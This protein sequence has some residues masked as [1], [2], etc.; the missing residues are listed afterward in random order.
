MA[1]FHF[2]IYC[3]AP[4]RVIGYEQERIW[5]AIDAI[6][7]ARDNDDVSFHGSICFSNM[8][9]SH[10]LFGM[11]RY[12]L[13][14]CA[15]YF[16]PARN[17][18]WSASCVKYWAELLA[19]RSGLAGL[20]NHSRKFGGSVR[21]MVSAFLVTLDAPYRQYHTPTSELRAVRPFRPAFYCRLPLTLLEGVSLA[22]PP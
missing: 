10:S 16:A 7:K 14:T 5:R 13:I 9:V 22:V 15:P 6:R 18:A 1:L 20:C 8:F 12:L 21:G 4:G 2:L 19:F 11:T 17:A 3:K